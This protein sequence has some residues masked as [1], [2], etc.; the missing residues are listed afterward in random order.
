MKKIIILAIIGLVIGLSNMYGQLIITRNDQLANQTIS[1]KSFNTLVYGATI[2]TEG[3]TSVIHSIVFD[4]TGSCQG[5]ELFGTVNLYANGT[6]VGTSL[7]TKANLYMISFNDLSLHVIKD[8]DLILEIK[9]TF[10]APFVSSGTLQLIPYSLA[11]EDETT[12]NLVTTSTKPAGATLTL[13]TASATF[14][15]SPNNPTPQLLLSPSNG[16]K[17]LAFKAIAF[18]DNF[19]LSDVNLNG[20]NLGIL[21]NLRLVDSSGT[22]IATAT[23]NTGT[24][25]TFIQ[26]DGAP[27]ILKDQSASYYIVADVNANTTGDISLTLSSGSVESV[28]DATITS[29][30]SNV[31]AHHKIAENTLIVAKASNPN[32]LITTSALRF[33][34]TAAGKNSVSL[35]QFAFTN[36]LAGYSGNMNLVVYKDAVSAANKAGELNTT[37]GIVTLTSNNIVDAGN[38][39]TYIVAIEGAISSSEN[40]DWSVSLT[41]VVFAGLNASDYLN[42]GSFPMTEVKGTIAG[43]EE[44]AGE[45]KISIYPN[46]TTEQIH[47]NT[48]IR[49]EFKI[50][51]VSGNLVLRS[52]ESNINVSRLSSGVYMIQGIGTFVKK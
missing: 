31:S 1:T 27:V 38:T 39:V 32:Q 21:S 26:I 28:S 9:V 42:V 43:I 15:T 48:D 14:S 17:L 37:T 45:E 12:A 47:I 6:L 34:V 4:T 5:G 35:S 3:N 19:R 13:A 50:F 20:T 41:N 44:T 2:S 10:T 23:T 29:I 49:Q 7:L 52:T 51:G 11:A 18:G 8:K 16:V 46:P 36:A 40:R 30:T 25:V 22:T 33:T 24:I